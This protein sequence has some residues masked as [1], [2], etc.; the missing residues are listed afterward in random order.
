[1]ASVFETGDDILSEALN[2]SN[3]FPETENDFFPETE[4]DW[5]DGTVANL[6]SETFMPSEISLA[7]NLPSISVLENI[8]Q[9]ISQ[10]YSMASDTSLASTSRNNSRISLA[11]SS[12]FDQDMEFIQDSM[13]SEICFENTSLDESMIAN[14]QEDEIIQAALQVQEISNTFENTLEDNKVKNN[15]L[16]KKRSK[17]SFNDQELVV[18]EGHF[19]KNNYPKSWTKKEI[20]EELGINQSIVV[21]WFNNRRNGQRK[22]KKASKANI[23]SVPAQSQPQHIEEPSSQVVSGM[24]YLEYFR[25]FLLNLS[26]LP[27]WSIKD[28]NVPQTDLNLF[29]SFLSQRYLPSETFFAIFKTF[30]SKLF[31]QYGHNQS[32]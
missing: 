20:A 8:S 1:M 12:N 10:E 6:S 29:Q 32:E 13:A 22:A 11:S 7:N 28:C 2:Q 14:F 31:T 19:L 27:Q 30:F 17:H 24:Q 26:D 21:A 16:G 23:K 25:V 9:D 18:L 15:E 3:I 5:T 4:N